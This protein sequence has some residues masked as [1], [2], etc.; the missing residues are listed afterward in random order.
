MTKVSIETLAQEIKTP[1]DTLL[2]QFADAG[3]EKTASDFV[4]Q[5][6]KEALLAHLNPQ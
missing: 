5:K 6:E 3:I 2:Q 4:S 1:V